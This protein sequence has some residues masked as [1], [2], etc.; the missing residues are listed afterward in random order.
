MRKRI[1]CKVT[2][3][4]TLGKIVE[5]RQGVCES[6]IDRTC[7]DGIASLTY[8]SR[9]VVTQSDIDDECTAGILNLC[10]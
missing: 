3:S 8:T 4:V 6:S 9:M 1:T 2:R 7:S 5:G 10:A